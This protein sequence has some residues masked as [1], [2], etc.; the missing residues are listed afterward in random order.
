MKKNIISIIISFISFT[1]LSVSVIII[2]FLISRSVSRLIIK[3][4][5]FPL[6]E[7][8]I[9][10]SI[11]MENRSVEKAQKGDLVGIKIPGVRKNDFV[12]KIETKK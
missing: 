12:Y 4:E 5:V 9:V 11:E 1:E 10:S 8:T 7:T 2:A 6:L 3:E